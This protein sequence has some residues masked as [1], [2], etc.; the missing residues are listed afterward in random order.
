MRHAILVHDVD[1]ADLVVAG[2]HLSPYQTIQ[3]L[4][5]R[6]QNRR[7]CIFL[8]DPLAQPS[9]VRANPHSP[10]SD[11]CDG[12]GLL[13]GARGLP[14]DGAAPAEVLHTDPH[15]AANHVS[16]LVNRA[17]SAVLHGLRR[18]G[19]A[20]LETLVVLLCEV[21]VF[22]PSRRIGGVDPLDAEALLHL[23]GQTH[24]GTAVAGDVDPRDALLAGVLRGP[25]V[26]QILLHTEGAHLVG[27]VVAN[28]H[29][30]TA[31]RELRCAH[32]DPP[33][34]HAALV[35]P[36]RPV[37]V[38]ELTTAV[39]GHLDGLEDPLGQEC[40]AAANH[41]LHP[42]TAGA[43]ERAGGVAPLPA[44][45]VSGAQEVAGVL[46]PLLLDGLL[47]QTQK[48]VDVYR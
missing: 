4:V 39:G 9:D 13:V 5:A 25:L 46:L 2:V 37:D 42:D 3:R 36:W 34:D 26:E 33:G 41:P 15:L 32:L 19:V 7:V 27:H 35:L 45:S 8:D 23:G 48:V 21:K 1:P 29:H 28:D 22:E 6:K 43:G 47:K 18:D 38:L 11:E 44:A 17:L 20:R 31:S 16:D 10:P 12:E 30:T 14:G 40:Q 24:S